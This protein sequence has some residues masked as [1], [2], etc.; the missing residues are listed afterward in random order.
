MSKPSSNYRADIDGLRGIAVLCVVLFHAGVA[1]FDGGFVGVDIFFVISGYLICGIIQREISEQRFSY[2]KFY[3]RRARRILP[4]LFVVLL[5]CF[6]TG[7]PVMTGAEMQDF[8]KSAVANIAAVSNIYFWKS[9]NYFSTSAELKPL[10]MT[11]S[12]S[13]EEQFYL[14]FPPVLLLIRRYK[15]SVG[16]VLA[17]L[18]A[19]SLIASVWMTSRNPSTAFFLLP[20]RAWELGI[21]ALLAH[22]DGRAALARRAPPAWVKQALGAGGLVAVLAAVTLYDH[23]TAFPGIAA[24]LP[25]LGAAMLIAANGSLVNRV[26]LGSKALVFVGLVSYSWYLWHWP[27]LS[28]ARLVAD[29]PLGVGTALVL[30]ALAF[31]L[32]IASWRFVERP[33]RTST[34]GDAGTLWRYGAATA[35]MLAVGAG[36]AAGR[37]WPQRLPD[38][39]VAIERSAPM[40]GDVCLVGYGQTALNLS[41]ACVAAAGHGSLALIGDSHAAA[42]AGG[43]R[44]LASRQG[45]GFNQL[46]KASCPALQGVSRRMLNQPPHARECASFNQAALARVR[47]DPAIKTVVLAGYWSAPFDQ[48]AAGQRFVLDT[49]PDAEVTPGQSREYLRQGLAATVGMMTAAGKTVVLVK[50]VPM[51]GFDPVRAVAAALIPARKA[52]ATMLGMPPSG[53]GQ[54]AADSLVINKGD[55]ASAYIDDIGRRYPAVMLVDPAATLCA[56]GRCSYSGRADLYYLDS[57]HLTAVGGRVMLNQPA[58][59]A[60]LAGQRSATARVSSR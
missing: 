54:T 50:D 13:V 34:T 46:T 48:E 45:I 1:G 18:T 43:L 42:I 58:I 26:I 24:A 5:V 51:F 44:A 23:T 25:V 32:A 16:G 52:M 35:V 57:Q 56:A 3:A 12:L 21:G 7:A 30:V 33:F 59:V 27:M 49:Q 55:V 11:W 47:D 6:V 40:P 17:A 19:L 39:F 29:R 37:G 36:L 4:A 38:D 2:A 53:D 31:L 60:L 14:F 9:A 10:M 15:W 41:P 20:A 22:Y 28:F 8:S